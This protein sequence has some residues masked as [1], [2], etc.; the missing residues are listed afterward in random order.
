MRRLL[1]LAAAVLAVSGTLAAAAP[2]PREAVTEASAA[3]VRITIPDQQDPIVLGAVAWPV[4]P[5][6]EVQ[7]FSYPNDGSVVSVGLSSASVSAQMGTSAAAQASAE[8]I[9]LSLFGGEVLAA[10]V[11][12]QASA[13]ASTGSAG[14]DVAESAVQGLRVLGRDIESVRGLHALEDW[15]TPT[16]LS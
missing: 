8:T 9:A 14:A 3:I 6:A 10:Q 1:L 2:P 12:A 15:G 16:V 5:S 11:V 4:T 13:G 7:S